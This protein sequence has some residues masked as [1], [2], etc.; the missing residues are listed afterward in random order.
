M[1]KFIASDDD[2]WLL[3]REKAPCPEA[4]EWPAIGLKFLSRGRFGSFSSVPATSL[5]IKSMIAW[6]S[7]AHAGSLMPSKA[8]EWTK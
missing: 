6:L 4:Q 8:A 7:A 3:P 1:A 5:T 2:S